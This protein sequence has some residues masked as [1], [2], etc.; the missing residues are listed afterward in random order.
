MNLD[1]AGLHEIAAYAA[2]LFGVVGPVLAL[3]YATRVER[4]DFWRVP[5][6]V[7]ATLT[8]ATTLTS[9][10]I[11]R[12]LGDDYSRMLGEPSTWAHLEYAD[13]LLLPAAAFFVIAVVTGVLNARTGVLKTMLPLLLTGFAVIV[14]GLTVLSDTGVRAIVD[15]LLA[16]FQ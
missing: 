7:G 16:E 12:R 1:L 13:G 4:R 14:L 10:L 6:L 11:G 15:R 9:Y 2:V 3:L 8:L 5:M